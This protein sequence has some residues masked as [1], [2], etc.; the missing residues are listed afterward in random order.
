MRAAIPL[1][2]EA[3]KSLQGIQKK[4]FVTA[5]SFA[6]P[7]GGVPEVFAACMHLMAG[8][9]NE[10]I[11]VDKNKKPKSVEWKASVKMMKNPDEFVSRL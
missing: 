8:H 1:V 10:A 6:N 3:K 9:W 7:P 5:K 2:E 4:D 11:D